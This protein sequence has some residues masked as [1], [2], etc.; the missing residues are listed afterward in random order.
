[1]YWL[2]AELPPSIPP[3]CVERAASY[4]DV[5]LPLLVSVLH[6]EGGKV[7]KAYPRSTGTYYGPGQISNKWVPRFSQWGYTAQQLTDNPCANVTA[8]AYVLAYYEIRERDWPRAIARYNVGSLD[9]PAQREAGNRY[10]NSV[11]NR[12]WNL[13]NKWVA[14]K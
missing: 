14:A 4:Y 5:P 2:A 6:Q 9:T 10:A 1:M 7:G 3:A 12:W 11:L 13:Y 8:S